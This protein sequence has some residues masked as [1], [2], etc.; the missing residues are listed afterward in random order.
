MKRLAILGLLALLC[1]PRL[2]H[3]DA[4]RCKQADG[5]L[6]FQDQ[7]CQAGSSGSQ[8]GLKPA[9]GY[10]P[11]SPD[12]SGQ[13]APGSPRPDPNAAARA[14][15]EANNRTIRCNAARHELG[16]MQ[17]QRPAYHYDNNGNKVYVEDKDRPAAIATAKDTIES[18]CQ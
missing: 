13:A 4:Y 14:Q 8:I 16:V 11:P 1:V 6:A 9:Q 15:V 10:A 5:S 12:Q 2:A 17:E 18:D 3:A 7:P